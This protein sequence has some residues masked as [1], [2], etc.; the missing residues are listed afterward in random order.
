MREKHV[1]IWIYNMCDHF[2][3][4]FIQVATLGVLPSHFTGFTLAF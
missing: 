3:Q 4:V 2:N 1:L